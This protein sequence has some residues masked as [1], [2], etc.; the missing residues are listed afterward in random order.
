MTSITTCY[1]CQSPYDALEAP[2]CECPVGAPTLVCPA[3]DSCF[4]LATTGYKE[5]FWLVAPDELWRRRTERETI[6]DEAEPVA[7]Q[8]ARPIVLVVCSDLAERIETRK[9]LVGLGCGLVF[10]ADADQSLELA[11]KFQPALL[12]ADDRVDDLEDS[13]F[14]RA[15]R[16][17]TRLNG[18]KVAILSSLYRTESQRDEARSRLDI[19]EILTRPLTTDEAGRLIG[20]LLS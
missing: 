19:D 5:G 9:V 14:A 10:A 15:L 20:T 3:C 2:W 1:H 11:R 8:L 7:G 12:I 16:A 13:S 6:A 17:E 4:C 18:T